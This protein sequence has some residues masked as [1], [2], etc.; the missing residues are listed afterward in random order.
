MPKSS[1]EKAASL[2]NVAGKTEYLLQE[3]ETRSMFVPLY[4]LSTQSGLRTLISDL[5]PRNKKEQG[6]Y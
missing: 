5:K 3:T 2:T 4:K 1:G 6:I